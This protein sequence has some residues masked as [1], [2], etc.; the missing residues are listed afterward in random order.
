MGVLKIVVTVEMVAVVAVAVVLAVV[1]TV[2][3]VEVVVVVGRGLKAGQLPYEWREMVV[4]MMMRATTHPVS[5]PTLSYLELCL[6]RKPT[7][8]R[9]C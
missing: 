6:C 8:L 4:M 5:T 2:V 1:V 7:E 9:R 3:V